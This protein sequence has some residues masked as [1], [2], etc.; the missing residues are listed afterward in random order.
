MLTTALCACAAIL[1]AAEPTSE[2]VTING[3]ADDV[4]LAATL[5]LPEGAT[6][7]EPAPCVVLI[8]GS[9]PQDRDESIAGKKP[10]RV[11]AE[12]LAAHGYATLRYDD[13][14][15]KGLGLGESTG[16]FED[17]TTADFAED[18]AA[19]VA[20]AAA[21]PRIDGARV[22]VCGHSTGG[23]V[24]AMLLGSDRVPAA[25]VLLAP[26]AVRGADLLAHQSE[27]IAL[28]TQQTVGTGLSDEQLAEMNAAQRA[29]VLAMATD[30]EERQRE[31]AEGAIR[32]QMKIAGMDPAA[33]P[34]GTIE[35]ATEQALAP[36]RATWMAYFLRY[37]PAD[38]L[39]AARVPVLAVFGGRDL[40][41]TPK[42]NV[43][44]MR[45]VLLEA[46]DPRS[47]V[48]TLATSN[49][50][51]QPAETGLLDEYEKLADEMQPMLID[52]VAAWL[53]RVVGEER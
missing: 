10:F 32:A 15:T 20:F 33:I 9:G 3:P 1:C 51:F 24:S 18:A 23:L 41:V 13:R 44:P 16:S 39:R 34:P 25:A 48:I 49:H 46:G 37:D 14:G 4:T 30:D 36:L 35:T 29:V 42:Q 47:A 22:V 27:A 8:T 11:L 6:E 5:L 28:A 2:D 50:L 31:A 52:L 40:Q 17:S 38:D 53:D 7:S 19:V 43:E 45:D 21:D 26:P 12:G